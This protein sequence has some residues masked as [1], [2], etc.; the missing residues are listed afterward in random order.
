VRA[1]DCATHRR[2]KS[3]AARTRTDLSAMAAPHALASVFGLRTASL[4]A[5]PR[6]QGFAVAWGRGFLA[7]LSADIRA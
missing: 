3:S 6:V 1:S 5:L 4:P 2:L 7:P